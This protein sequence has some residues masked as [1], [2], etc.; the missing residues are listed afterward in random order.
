MTHARRLMPADPEL[1]HSP[2]IM[3]I[4]ETRKAADPVEDELEAMLAAPRPS[5]PV[6]GHWTLET[7]LAAGASST[8]SSGARPLSL[9]TQAHGRAPGSL[10]R[11][12]L[13]IVYFSQQVTALFE[14][15]P[16]TI[17]SAACVTRIRFSLRVP[18][19]A[20]GVIQ[21]GTPR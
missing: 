19:R 18:H 7:Q 2:V 12:R 4:A 13:Y 1:R 14:Q 16:C 6:A 17:A 8:P 3:T 21:T 11:A 15:G 5:A 20:R 9:L 10:A